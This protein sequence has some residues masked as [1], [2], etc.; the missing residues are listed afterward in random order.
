MTINVFE[1]ISKTEITSSS[2]LSYD[3]VGN[4]IIFNCFESNGIKVANI[5]YWF[6]IKL[7]ETGNTNEPIYGPYS[8]N[9]I[10]IPPVFVN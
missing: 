6:N 9:V 2:P 3:I 5:S 10:L 8:F 1:T 4:K 7:S